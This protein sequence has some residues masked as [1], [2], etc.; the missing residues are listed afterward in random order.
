MN[1]NSTAMESDNDKE[2][3]DYL[4]GK[5]NINDDDMLKTNPTLM[6]KVKE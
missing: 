5:L 2:L 1:N 4:L 3:F 6:K